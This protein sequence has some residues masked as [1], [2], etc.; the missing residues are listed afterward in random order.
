MLQRVA[1]SRRVFALVTAL[2][3][4]LAVL[5]LIVPDQPE[6]VA[7]PH[8][9][10]PGNYP[11]DPDWPDV[12]LILQNKCAACH[13]P[14]SDRIDL[15]SYA[16]M[17]DAEKFSHK[18]IVPG[19]PK[20]SLLWEYVTWNVHQHPD[21]LSP[22]KPEMPPEKSEWLT[23][24]QLETINRWITNGALEF[25]L[26]VHCKPPVT[27][28]DFPSA[29]QCKECH[30]KQYDEWSRSMHAYGQQSPIFEAFTLTLLERTG[31]TIGT[32]CTRCHTPI[33]IALGETGST[34]N[35]HRSRLSLEGV[36]C[37]TCHR[38]NT[39]HYKSSGRVPVTPGGLLETCMFGPFDD[40]PTGPATGTHPSAA[41]PYMKSS[42][43]CG[44]CHDVTSADGVRL[45]EAFS[46]WQNSPAAKMGQTCQ[47]CHMGP[48]QGK[49]IADCNRPL[50]YAAV[51]PGSKQDKL[52]LRHLTDHTFAGP[53]YSLLPDT[54]FPEKLDWMYETDYRDWDNLTRYQK[55]T[56][57]ALRKKNR[58]SLE[59]ADAKRYE[60]LKNAAVIHVDSPPMAKAGHKTAVRVD[61][62]SIM[63]G[64]SLPTGFTAERQVWVAITVRD[65]QGRVVF[66]SGDLDNN[67][68]L[69]DDH[70]FQVLSGEIPYDRD[71]L[72]FQ[73]KFVAL[74]NK[75][76]DRTVVLSVNRNIL[77]INVLRPNNSLSASFGRPGTF[78][79][80]KGSLPPLST[81][82]QTYKFVPE[83][84]GV[85]T[86]DVRLNF[87][88]LPPTLLDHIG[89][90]HLKHLLEIVVIDS[91]NGV[92]EVTP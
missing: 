37:V 49:S 19:K 54:E 8:T 26:P 42:Q 33:G 85:Y 53:D 67:A 66:A 31:G 92:I 71:L 4:A 57:T 56:L 76:T 87:R 43:F 91:W 78:R 82:G 51:V 20:E 90:P 24:G 58:R 64:H 55:E 45:E 89:T 10:T 75:G 32:F 60:V 63:A 3:G 28:M 70:S 17:I 48:V 41:F 2:I 11:Y 7:V 38:R 86:V 22:R 83:C 69:R 62:E 47:S 29:Q 77:P 44:E 61:V 59:I 18:L 79:I 27:E 68:D 72:N 36:T 23:A 65:Q 81:R 21:S 5:S 73:N 40:S 50:G 52:P 25:T 30:P 9:I 39:V 6:A 14:N 80:A 46:E 1:Q 15:S 35:V 12:Y 34:R 16:A 88:H 84:P 13:R 74:S